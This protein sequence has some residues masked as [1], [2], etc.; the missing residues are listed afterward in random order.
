MDDSD[1]VFHRGSYLLF[2]F[3]CLFGNMGVEKWI[4]S[5]QYQ[6]EVLVRIS[7]SDRGAKIIK[8]CA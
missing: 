2:V 8:G 4:R 7:I 3:I 5:L 1:G 6:E